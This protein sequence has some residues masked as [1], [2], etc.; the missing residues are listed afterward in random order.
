LHWA[1]RDLASAVERLSLNEK[2]EVAAP[3]DEDDCWVEG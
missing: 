3:L 1:F 2:G